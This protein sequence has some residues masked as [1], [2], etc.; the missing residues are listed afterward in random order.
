M[1]LSLPLAVAWL[2]GLGV[3]PPLPYSRMWMDDIIVLLLYHRISG[4]LPSYKLFLAVETLKNVA[5]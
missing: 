2:K 1:L 5:L 4:S 3:G